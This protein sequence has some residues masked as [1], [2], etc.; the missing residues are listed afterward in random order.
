MGLV[1]KSILDVMVL[2][3]HKQVADPFMFKFSRT[4]PVIIFLFHEATWYVFPFCLL[5][6][7]LGG[8]NDE[9]FSLFSNRRVC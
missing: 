2:L 3:S 4:W 8:A 6:F 1:V 9:K 7:R 5:R